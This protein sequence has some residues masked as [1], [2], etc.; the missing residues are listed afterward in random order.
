MTMDARH[1]ATATSKDREQMLAH[2]FNGRVTA[3]TTLT[4]FPAPANTLRD[5]Y[6]VVKTKLPTAT[7]TAVIGGLGK[8]YDLETAFAD[9]ATPPFR[10]ELKVTSG[11]PSPLEVL[12]WRPWI[13]TVQFLQGQVKSKIGQEFLG[14]CGQPMLRA[15]FSTHIEPFSISEEFSAIAPKACAMT[16]AGYE[17]AMSTIGMKGTQ[18]PAAIAFITAL[19]A[20]PQLQAALQ[21]QWLAFETKWFSEHTLNHDGLLKV[22]K[23]IIEV[24]NA[25][26]CVSKKGVNWID[27]L[28][29]SG[30]R[31]EGARPKPKGGMS[32]HYTLTL[33]KGGLTK[34]VPMECK[35][36]WKNGGQAVQNLNFML[37]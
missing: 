7:T 9:A 29:V 14:D 20:N 22:V 35:F 33:T 13:D 18:E 30:L 37:L 19:R 23:D 3:D 5:F 11:N 6:Q 27:G 4:M 15:W 12:E 10:S 1:T 17:K 32:F 2:L 16:F 36:H 31:F 21:A 25:W 8:H 26:I 24:K 28:K 34:E